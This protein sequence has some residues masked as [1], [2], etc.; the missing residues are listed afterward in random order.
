[1]KENDKIFSGE[2]NPE[3]D[4]LN[5]TLD[6]FIPEMS[7]SC[8]FT[9]E[10]MV[11]IKKDVIKD[12][13]VVTQIVDTRYGQ[14]LDKKPEGISGNIVV[15]AGRVKSDDFLEL[16]GSYIEIIKFSSL[17]VDDVKLTW[18]SEIKLAKKYDS[19]GK[20]TLIKGGVVSGKLA[21]NFKD[22]YFSKETSIINSPGS[23]WSEP[24]G[25]VGPKMMLIKSGVS[26]VGK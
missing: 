24:I 8:G 5:L 1:M 25:Y 19:D 7:L 2:K 9:K 18:S 21:E 17:L 15:P 10:G 13:T 20:V 6:P 16:A 11:A 23:V 26:I 4:V 22:F 14:Y 3:S 12:D